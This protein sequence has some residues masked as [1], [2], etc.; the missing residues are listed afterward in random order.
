MESPKL[1]LQLSP[2][3]LDKSLLELYKRV[4]EGPSGDVFRV[5]GGGGP[6]GLQ[7][8]YMKR[9]ASRKSRHKL[10]VG[11][12]LDLFP[13]YVDM[14]AS[15]EEEARATAAQSVRQALSRNLPSRSGIN[16]SSSPTKNPKSDPSNKQ[17]PS[18][19]FGVSNRKFCPPQSWTGLRAPSVPMPRSSSRMSLLV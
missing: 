18:M 7:N 2:A 5:I 14:S 6:V 12:P 17:S 11:D 9:Q 8:M 3:E 15:D 10:E 13:S 19:C 1:R 4:T 16:G